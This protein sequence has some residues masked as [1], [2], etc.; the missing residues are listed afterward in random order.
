MPRKS[1][2]NRNNKQGS[3]RS[4]HEEPKRRKCGKNS[5]T[6]RKSGNAS[7]RK[8]IEGRKMAKVVDL[9][10]FLAQREPELL[11]VP[12]TPLPLPLPLPP[13]LEELLRRLSR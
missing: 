2:K 7:R 5:R 11:V 10:G 9:L 6:L 13:P 8:K 3:R 1:P 12:V 4:R